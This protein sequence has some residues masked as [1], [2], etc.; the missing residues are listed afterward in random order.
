MCS[1]KELRKHH[2]F[3][4]HTA[5]LLVSGVRG[6]WD[7]SQRCLWP[8]RHKQSLF[9]L[10]FPHTAVTAPIKQ[11]DTWRN[12][13]VMFQ[14]S[15]HHPV[16]GRL[17]CRHGLVLPMIFIPTGVQLC[18]QPV[19]GSRCCSSSAFG[20]NAVL[21]LIA[22]QWTGNVHVIFVIY[23]YSGTELTYCISSLY[24]FYSV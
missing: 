9:F 14:P 19:L 13:V 11:H 20:S 18:Q 22:E 15:S 5:V 17:I 3:L 4:L 16:P 24:Y 1:G 21:M 12:M 7:M 23:I 10:R 2:M 6:V 8:W